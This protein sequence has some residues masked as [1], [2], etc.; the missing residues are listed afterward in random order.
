MKKILLLLVVCFACSFRAHAAYEDPYA[1]NYWQC[2]P[3]SCNETLFD[4]TGN[5]QTSMSINGNCWDTYQL[6]P[7]LALYTL[8]CELFWTLDLGGTLVS[9]YVYLGTKR[10]LIDGLKI[11]G[12]ITPAEGGF[13]AYEA[14]V[15]KWCDQIVYSNIPP[16][17]SPC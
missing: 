3:L 10:Y 16:P 8:N 11:D 1:L 15:E 4:A 13:A 14:V 5:S 6:N 7:Y 12:F 9:S 2:D 17:L